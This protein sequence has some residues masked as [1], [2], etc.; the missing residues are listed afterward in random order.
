MKNKIVWMLSLV[1]IGV[2]PALALAQAPLSPKH[3]IW[4][5]EEVPYIITTAERDVFY[6]LET[7]SDRD[8]LIEEFWKQRDPTPGTPR[9]EFREEHYRR[10]EFAN[11]TFGRGT[12]F[13]GWRTERGRIY[14]IL[15]PPRDVQRLLSSDA[16]PMEIWF[17]QGNP[18]FGQ[19]PFFRLLFYQKGGGG[20]YALYNP[21]ANSPKDLVGNRRR[22]ENTKGY[23]ADWDEWDIGAYLALKELV[24]PEAANASVSLIPSSSGFMDRLPSSILLAE[25]QKYPQKKVNDAYAYDFLEHKASVE[26]SYSVHFMGNRSAVSVLQ[27]PSGLFFLNYV[28]VPDNLSLDAYQDK[29]LADLRTTLRLSDAGGKTLFQQEKIIP[30]EL[31]MEELKAVEKNS[32]QFYDAVPLIPGQYTF[33]LLLENTVSKEFTSIEKTFFIPEGDPLWMSPP[34]LARK[35]VKDSPSGGASRA[36]QVGT[37]Q[38]YP[39]L[40][41]TFQAK[42]R[43][44]LFFQIHG[45]NAELKDNG[46]LGYSIIKDNQTLQS[47]RKNVRDY[48]GGRDFLEEFPTDKFSPGTYAVKIALFDKEGRE[49]LS[50]RADFLISDKAIPGTWVVAQTNPPVDDPYYAFV[51]GN[52]YM[53]KGD[54]NKAQIELFKAH[55]KKPDS[56]EYALSYARIL[57]RL[58]DPAVARDI[59]L[60]FAQKETAN[61]DLYNCLGNA[62][63]DLSEFKDAI[64]WYQKALSFKGNVIEILNSLGVCYFKIGDK[65]QALRAWQKSLEI[66]PKQENIEKMIE[67]LK[68]EKI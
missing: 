61:F 57:L 60:P 25:V 41:S 44:F 64:S 49:V 18:A 65:E 13:K 17:Y 22:V 45:L 31:R 5:E 8:L 40:N 39:C 46:V 62:Y 6:K 27:D 15:G 50:Q 16:Y 63:Q 28:I 38:I 10:I 7:D 34:V 67:K 36:Y 48:A 4:I 53:N 19:A 59:L 51:L 1:T 66:N 11:K 2:L 56:L 55:S 3:K 43:L 52:Q 9:N 42:D 68:D 21:S 32:F 37:L 24:S 23:P 14:I 26:V 20:D 47:S 58:N 30:I 12:P 35:V 33:N 29:Y 54:I